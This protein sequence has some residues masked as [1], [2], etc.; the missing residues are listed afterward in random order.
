MKIYKFKDLSDKGKHSH[1]LQMVLQNT[2]WCAS[3]DTLND[4]DEFK[5]ELDYEPSPNTA[6]LLSQVI[7]QYR[8]SKHRPPHVSAARVLENETLEGIA[9][10][11]IRK[12]INRSRNTIGI[13]SFSVIKSN[14]HLWNEYGGKG[15]GVCIEINIP[16]SLVG[17]SFHWV[18]YVPEKKFHVDSF[19]ESAL[20]SD[21]VFETYRK[22]LLTKTMKWSEE[23]EMRFIGKQQNVNWIID[24]HISEIIFGPH[25]PH[26]TLE[27]LAD[28]IAGNCRS[29][30]ITISRL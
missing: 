21:R 19:L 9:A 17:Q 5:F 20:F 12:G 8:T 11:I 27:Q 10:P 3:P 29:I 22:I 4:E 23:K 18:L 7:A 16:D 30:N 24:G 14:G 15:N 13:T 2:I 6:Y 1:F 26:N 28:K 25:V